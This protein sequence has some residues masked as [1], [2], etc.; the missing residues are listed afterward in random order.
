[1]LRGVYPQTITNGNGYVFLFMHL[2]N[3]NGMTWDFN[4]CHDAQGN[5]ISGC[6]GAN[7]SFTNSFT[8]PGGSGVFVRNA[9][10]GAL[11]EEFELTQQGDHPSGVHGTIRFSGPLASGIF[12][13]FQWDTSYF[14]PNNFCRESGA[15]VYYGNNMSGTPFNAFRIVYANPGANPTYAA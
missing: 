8:I 13:Q 1:R 10:Q 6:A 7:Y 3:D 5:V 9:G 14:G 2:S 11:D 12:K 15:G 4:S